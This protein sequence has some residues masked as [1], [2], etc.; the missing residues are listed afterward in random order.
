MRSGSIV[1]PDL[2]ALARVA[3]GFL[4]ADRAFPKGESGQTR[5]KT[6]AESLIVVPVSDGVVPTALFHSIFISHSKGFAIL[7]PS[8]SPDLDEHNRRRQQ[9]AIA[10]R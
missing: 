1:A 5:F 8:R 4:S 7:D 3:V 10:F 9:E 2:F 6:V